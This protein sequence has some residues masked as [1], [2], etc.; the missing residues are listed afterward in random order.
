VD[1]QFAVVVFVL[2]SG[3]VVLQR[4]TDDAP[5][6]P[7]LLGCFGGAVEGHESPDDA[8]RREIAEETS[9]DPREL[10]LTK[11]DVVVV[12]PADDHP[13]TRTLHVYVSPIPAADFEVYEGVAAEVHAPGDLDGRDDVA[14]PVGPTIRAALRRPST[15]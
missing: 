7:G 15:G 9:L 6:A 2:P 4:R 14:V 11:R 5:Y 8:V 13:V 10:Q 12:P 3:E 1:D